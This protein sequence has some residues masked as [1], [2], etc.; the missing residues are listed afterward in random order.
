MLC[1]VSEGRIGDEANF[2]DVFVM[3]SDEAKMRHHRS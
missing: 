3:L 2:L 1:D